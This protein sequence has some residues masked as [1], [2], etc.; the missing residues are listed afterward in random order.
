MALR[1]TVNYIIIQYYFQI[2]IYTLDPLNE[3]NQ[4]SCD[5]DV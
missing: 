3:R 1:F 4:E 5:K 2:L